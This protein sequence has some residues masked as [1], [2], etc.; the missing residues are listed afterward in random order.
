MLCE[1]HVF[2]FTEE[3]FKKLPLIQNVSIFIEFGIEEKIIIFP[4]CE[5]I[6]NYHE[7]NITIAWF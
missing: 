1:R 7:N 2:M 5:K 3:K 6:N 4:H